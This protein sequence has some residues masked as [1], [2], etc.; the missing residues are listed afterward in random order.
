MDMAVA[1]I[2]AGAALGGGIMGGLV[3]FFVQARAQKREDIRSIVNFIFSKADRDFDRYARLLHEGDPAFPYNAVLF[4]NVT[5]VNALFNAVEF[6]L[7]YRKGGEDLLAACAQAEQEAE[8]FYEAVELHDK[9]DGR[10]RGPDSC[11]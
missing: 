7:K 3:T 2:T 10:Q 11:A 4:G 8:K 6:A 9:N 1:A 5:K